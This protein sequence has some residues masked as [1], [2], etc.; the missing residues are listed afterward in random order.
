MYENSASLLL[1]GF[2]IVIIIIIIRVY[3]VR[4]QSKT[5]MTDTLF[6]IHIH[7]GILCHLPNAFATETAFFMSS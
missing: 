5:T 1:D 6:Y 3:N 4:M 2:I 7:V